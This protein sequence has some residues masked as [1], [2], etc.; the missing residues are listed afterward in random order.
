MIF[1]TDTNNPIAVPAMK[2]GVTTMS[3]GKISVYEDDETLYNYYVFDAAGDIVSFLE[4]DKASGKM[5]QHVYTKTGGNL[6]AEPAGSVNNDTRNSLFGDVDPTSMVST[7]TATQIDESGILDTWLE[8][9]EQ[10][11]PIAAIV[12]GVLIPE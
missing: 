2:E 7:D 3:G 4:T 5:V 11:I 9:T 6:Y 12:D 10:L 1:L 8:T